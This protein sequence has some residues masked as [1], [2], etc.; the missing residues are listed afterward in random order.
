[1]V[2]LMQFFLNKILKLICNFLIVSD[3]KSKK[4]V[5]FSQ[6]QNLEKSFL[7]RVSLMK[8]GEPA[9]HSHTFGGNAEKCDDYLIV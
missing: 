2:L 5:L 8:W 6:P 9:T 3:Y 7:P 1:M 4:V